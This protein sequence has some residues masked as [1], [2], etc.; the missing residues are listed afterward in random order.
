MATYFR[1]RIRA[2]FQA[3]LDVRTAILLDGFATTR[4][5]RVFPEGWSERS[6]RFAPE[7]L[8]AGIPQLRELAGR[9]DRPPISH[10]LVAFRYQGDSPLKHEDRERLWRAF[11]VPVF[12]QYLDNRNELLATEC[13]AHAGLHVVRAGLDLP[14][15]CTPCACGNAA[16]RLQ[17]TQPKRLATH[18]AVA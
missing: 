11:G 6:S 16:P 9:L 2:V 8:A 14:L 10:A 13:I 1:P 12:E 15:D 4:R 17:P 3:P 7:M 18:T 5:V